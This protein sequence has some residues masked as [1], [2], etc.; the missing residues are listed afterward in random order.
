MRRHWILALTLVI[1]LT[2][3]AAGC[4]DDKKDEKAASPAAS[5]SPTEVTAESVLQQAADQ[6]TQ[7]TSAHFVLTVDGNAYIDEAQS[8]RL[9]SA[10]GDIKRP[11]SVKATAKIDATVAQ[12]NVSLIFIGDQAWMTNLITG[13]WDK[14]PA[15]FSYNPAVLFSDTEGI[16]PILT[17]LQNPTLDGTESIDG[18]SA[19]KVTGAVD[20]ATVQKI[21]AG[22]IQ[23]QTI[24]VSVWVGKDDG[25]ILQ[26]QLT[27]PQIE[28]R[29]PATWTLKLTKHNESVEIAPPQSS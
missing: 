26:V 14:A 5:P 22:S 18:K 6:W 2:F 7:T 21:T 25:K 3:L 20:S 8:I 17:K 4:R 27:E 16:G 1:V 15:D 13:T 10:E 11:D 12:A 28:G 19:R 23:G 9:I 24:D 29:E